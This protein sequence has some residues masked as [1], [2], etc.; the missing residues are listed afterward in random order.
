VVESVRWRT[1]FTAEE[2]E[3]AT[4]RLKEY[5]YVPRLPT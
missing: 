5:R 1:L 2:L 3:R 4:K